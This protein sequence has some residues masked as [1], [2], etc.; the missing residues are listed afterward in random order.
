MSQTYD[1]TKPIS[2]VTKWSE[3][4]Q[5][6]RNHFEVL[7]S[8]FSG[9][10]FP[11][12]PV[13]VEGQ[14]F[15]NTTTFYWY[16]YSNGN[17]REVLKED[18]GIGL[19]VIASRGTKDSVDARLDVSINE[20]GTLRAG[21]SLNP[22]QWIDPEL[23]EAY[24]NPTTFTVVGN[25]T[26]IYLKDRRLKFSLP[27][28]N[29]FSEVVISSYSSGTGLTT[30][31]IKDAILNATLTKVEHSIITPRYS[32][33]GDGAVNYKT[34]GAHQIIIETKTDNYNLTTDDFG[35][36]FIMN[37]ITPKTF[38]L[39]SV[40][41]GEIGSWVEFIK[42]PSGELTIDAADNDV[43]EDSGLGDTIYC[44]GELGYSSLK[45]KLITETLWKIESGIGTWTTT[46]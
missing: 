22:S 4:Y 3:L 34:V 26:D 13:P 14:P 7:R 12:D 40:T 16:I 41:S 28:G 32:S 46:D 39:P 18:T 6:L 27:A 44:S 17:W 23:T 1:D 19:E 45:L 9:T 35:K 29:N 20:D 38:Y 24:K 42:V 37:T 21:T 2:G 43:I 31:V 33:L 36:T 10:S 15:F 5:I 25:H 30:V 8:S 11:I